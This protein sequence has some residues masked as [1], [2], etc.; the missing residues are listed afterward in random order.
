[1]LFTRVRREGVPVVTHSV[2][3]MVFPE[4]TFLDLT[5]LGGCE[6]HHGSSGFNVVS[7][8]NLHLMSV[9]ISPIPPSP[10]SVSAFFSLTKDESKRPKYKE[11]LVSA[12]GDCPQRLSWLCRSHSGAGSRVRGRSVSSQ[13]IRAGSSPPQP[14]EEHHLRATVSGL[15][16]WRWARSLVPVHKYR[17][18]VGGDVPRCGGWVVPEAGRLG[19]KHV[20]RVNA[21]FACGAGAVPEP[22][23]MAASAVSCEC[24][25]RTGHT[26]TVGVLRQKQSLKARLWSRTPAEPVWDGGS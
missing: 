22:C 6:S 18:A 17:R 5:G 25:Q 26:M 8:K 2:T 3:R 10:N 11:L 4:D 16:S 14:E 23:R 12:K 20:C 13:A 21:A 24:L 9:T 1:M 7:C 19:Q 15:W